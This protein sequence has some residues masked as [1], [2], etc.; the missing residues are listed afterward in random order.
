MRGQQTWII[1]NYNDTTERIITLDEINVEHIINYKLS[2]KFVTYI[3]HTISEKCHKKSETDKL[4]DFYCYLQYIDYIL[5]SSIITRYLIKYKN[6]KYLSLNIQKE[7]IIIN[8]NFN[9][10]NLDLRELYDYI[11][12]SFRCYSTYYRFVNDFNTTHL[13]ITFFY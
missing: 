7:N 3:Y 10:N 2:D 5:F 8:N 6:Y 13:T 9:N 1:D 4:D 12:D 11:L